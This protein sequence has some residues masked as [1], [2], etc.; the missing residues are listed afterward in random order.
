M[1]IHCEKGISRS[2]SV[3]AVRA[4]ACVLVGAAWK[5][6]PIEGYAG[7]A[8]CDGKRLPVFAV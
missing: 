5:A 4:G 3:C 8:Q 1:L 7:S 6:G 2:V